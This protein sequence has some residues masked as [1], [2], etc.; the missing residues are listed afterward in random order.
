M[1]IEQEPG[2]KPLVSA[3]PPT[4]G[5]LVPEKRTARVVRFVLEDRMVSYPLAELKRWELVAGEPE[6]LTI[7]TS[8]EAVV[9]E[10]KDLEAVHAALDLARLEELRCNPER[11]HAR[12]GPK[13]RRI[14][15]KPA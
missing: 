14:T 11:T 8:Q 3:P 7:T 4:W 1:S 15:I 10:G 12:P 13:V 9:I 6:L 5:D 2:K